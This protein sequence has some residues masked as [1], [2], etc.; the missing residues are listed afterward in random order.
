MPVVEPESFAGPDHPIR[1]VTRQVAFD[2]GWDAERA[3]KVTAL[4]NSMAADWTADHEGPDRSASVTDALRRGDLASGVLLELG[5]GTGLGT[6]VL[7]EARGGTIVALDLAAEMLNNA[8]PRYGERV[9]GDSAALPVRDASVGVV[10]L[11]NALLFPAE[12]DRVL[13]P[14]GTVVWV[15]TIGDQTPIHLSPEDVLLAL[16]GEWDGVVSQAGTG[17]WLAARRAAR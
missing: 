12:V 17:I 15:N 2:G 16:P 3:G 9:Q 4:F 7:R 13:R 10:V 11:V 5:S 1:K 14:G 6:R 8:P